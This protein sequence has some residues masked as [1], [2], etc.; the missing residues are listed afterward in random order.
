MYVICGASLL[1]LLAG[2][3]IMSKNGRRVIISKKV[4]FDMVNIVMQFKEKDSVETKRVCR[5]Y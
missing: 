1:D 2:N 4:G 5:V 3:F